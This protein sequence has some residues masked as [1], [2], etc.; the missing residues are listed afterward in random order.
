MHCFG[1]VLLR[2][3]E[4]APKPRSVLEDALDLLPSLCKNLGDVGCG[5]DDGCDIGSPP[6]ETATERIDRS[7][8]IFRWYSAQDFND[9]HRPDL[10]HRQS[11][12]SDLLTGEDTTGVVQHDVN[13]DA[14]LERT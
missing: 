12:V 3:Q 8:E 1:E 4:R 6:G 10:A 9:R 2:I 14:V 5:F 7:L 13:L 11:S